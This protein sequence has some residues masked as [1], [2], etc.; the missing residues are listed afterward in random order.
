[1][2]AL[3]AGLG[4]ALLLLWPAVLN[5]YPI[6]FSDTGALLAQ[7]VTGARIWDKP[8]VYAPVMAALH[9]Q[10]SLWPVALAQGA[11]LSWVL[12]LT[13]RGVVGRARAGVHLGVC[14]GLAALTAAPW[15]AAL[16]L[17]DILAPVLVLAL[18]LLGWAGDR[19]T[20]RERLGL[21]AVATL[22]AAAHLAH[23]PLAAAVIALVVLARRGW[24]AL[25][26]CAAPLGLALLV[27]AVGNWDRHG[28]FAVSPY[29]S[30]FLLARLVADGPAARVI[31]AACAATPAPAWHMCGWAGRLPTD[32]D[33]FLWAG[34]GPLWAPRRDGA[35]PGGPISLA[36][37]ASAIVAATI[38]A[39]PLGVLRAVLRN[40]WAQAGLVRVGDTLGPEHL[41]ATVADQLA[42]GFP[43][44]EQARFAA[45]LQARGALRD[46][47]SPF[48]WW[49]PGVL[50][51]GLA[52]AVL[53][54]ARTVDPRA[55]GMV[56]AVLVAV[57]ANAVVTGGLS[58][59]HDRYQARIAWLLPLMGALVLSHRGLGR[60][61]EP[62]GTNAPQAVA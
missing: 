7:T 14:A 37:E 46:A 25:A 60:R 21:A 26:W 2:I 56:L 30:V 1:M 59:P 6:V 42:R 9:W 16:L 33:A 45:S 27:L 39:E 57:A 58:G 24:R 47:A 10:W 5:G 4:G 8:F 40:G 35:Q 19:L 62:L 31:D 55:R 17:P 20:G 53:A 32:S 51:L 18:A 61:R 15:F 41:Q 44:A 11:L 38:A 34:D 50:A 43:A 29:G 13:Q 54:L 22:A 23:L 36:P 28:R 12:W 48:V 3:L 49:Q 52:A